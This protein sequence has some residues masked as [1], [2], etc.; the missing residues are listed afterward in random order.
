MT[1]PP[2]A[3]AERDADLQ[4]FFYSCPVG[5]LQMDE[6]GTIERL[7]PAAVQL[8]RLLAP[9]AP[10]PQVGES[11]VA[12]LAPLGTDLRPLLQRG[13]AR[14]VL[15]KAL[16]LRGPSPAQGPATTLSLWL[17]RLSGRPLFAMLSDITKLALREHEV[18]ELTDTMLRVNKK[19]AS[20][21]QSLSQDLELAAHLQRSLLP[22]PQRRPPALEVAWHLHTSA[23]LSGSLCNVLPI[24]PRPGERVALV[25][26]DAQGGGVAAALLCGLLQQTLHTL[27]TPHPGAEL[28]P[29]SPDVAL[30]RLGREFPAERAGRLLAAIYADLDLRSGALRYATADRCPIFWL[31]AVGAPQVLCNAGPA[32]G[33]RD[34][35]DP[36]SYPVGEARLQG[37]DRLLLASRGLLR[38]FGQKPEDAQAELLRLFTHQRP[39]S[40]EEL[41]SI[42]EHLVDG[43]LG[44]KD[45]QGDAALLALHYHGPR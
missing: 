1:P 13:A 40:V 28:P 29:L 6:A 31:P 19:L 43:A 39:R 14:E 33:L 42:V 24:G 9:A 20:R 37:G 36:A 18:A 4:D 5:I 10:E 38:A 21:Q 44:G 2:R 41:C 30:A 15:C 8:L 26:V 11:L 45:P 23:E 35:A 7:N 25:M 22:H 12:R 32:L 34:S 3:A 16:A 27:V 17:A